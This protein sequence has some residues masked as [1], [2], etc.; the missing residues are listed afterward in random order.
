MQRKNR[1]FKSFGNM[2]NQNFERLNKILVECLLLMTRLK[3]S[4]T[5]MRTSLCVGITLMLK[6]NVLRGSIYYQGLFAMAM[7][8]CQSLVN[9]FVRML[10]FATLQQEKKK[11]YRKLL[12]S[13]YAA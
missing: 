7:L 4:L 3:R 2:L 5:Q 8:L 6:V 9:Q 13:P 11:E 1:F 12:D 10:C